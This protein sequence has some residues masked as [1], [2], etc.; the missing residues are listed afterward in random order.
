MSPLIASFDGLRLNG[1]LFNLRFGTS[2]TSGT[3][4]ADYIVASQTQSSVAPGAA[5]I[6]ID[7]PFSNVTQ[8]LPLPD[9]L[10]WARE[11]AFD[12]VRDRLNVAS[13]NPSR[14]MVSDVG[15]GA[16]LDTLTDDAT[17]TVYSHLLTG[18][19]TASLTGTLGSMPAEITAMYPLLVAGALSGLNADAVWLP[20][21]AYQVR[22]NTRLND[23]WFVG[24]CGVDFLVIRHGMGVS[25]ARSVHTTFLPIDFLA[26]SSHVPAIARGIHHLS[27]ERRESTENFVCHGLRG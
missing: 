15:D 4:R 2:T 25:E 21:A 13:I 8:T 24:D 17:A 14:F 20:G 3:T 9:T 22:S 16:R 19:S 26:C 1:G 23:T 18:A 27:G 11:R 10:R 5:G 7:S 12:S 6:R